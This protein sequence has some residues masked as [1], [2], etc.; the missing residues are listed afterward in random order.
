[1]GFEFSNIDTDGA[2][3][4]RDFLRK[5]V[6]NVVK[7]SS[8]YY[9]ETVDHAFYYRERQF[10]SIV[11]PSI[12]DI[13]Y[14]Y[15]ME[16]PL[17][18]KPAGENETYGFADYWISYRNYSFLMEMKHT[19]FAYKNLAH[20]RKSIAEKFNDALEQL[21]NVRREECRGL[22]I[23]NYDLI[24]IALEIIVFYEGSKK[25]IRKKLLRNH[26]FAKSFSQLIESSD[27]NKTPNMRALWIL[28]S[29]MV[30]PYV[31]DDGSSEI[32]PA[33]GFIANISERQ[34][35]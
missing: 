14:S 34:T 19:Y 22:V 13:T 24:K 32:Y 30:E 3:V 23:C 10:H 25:K 35:K 27:F 20:P 31:Y 29:G 8:M 7:R 16:H 1:M 2:R 5:L 4:S 33:V 21:K 26:D 18:R 15:L 9:N 11:C 17:K 12:A 28:R 6:N